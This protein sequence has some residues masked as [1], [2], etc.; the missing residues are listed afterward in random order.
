MRHFEPFPSPR[1]PKFNRKLPKEAVRLRDSPHSRNGSG[2]ATIA[3]C[4]ATL[5]FEE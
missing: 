5:G 1:G 2:C 4:Y 3:V